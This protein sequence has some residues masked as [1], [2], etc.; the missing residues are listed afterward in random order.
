M[1][2]QTDRLTDDELRMSAIDRT[3]PRQRRMAAELLE[4]RARVAELEA[5]RDQAQS[6]AVQAV[7]D[8][9]PIDAVRGQLDIALRSLEDERRRVGAAQSARNTLRAMLRCADARIAEL[10][11]AHAAAVGVARDNSRALD[12]T[13]AK[14]GRIGWVTGSR[15]ADGEW[16]ISFDGPPWATLERALEDVEDAC[17]EQPLADWRALA[18]YDEF[19]EPYRAQEVAGRG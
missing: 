12:E 16:L 15:Y 17:I 4:L 8:M 11:V 7:A 14:R 5:E 13:R 10:E 9:E 3:R 2:D 18:I 19:G 6:E 1:P